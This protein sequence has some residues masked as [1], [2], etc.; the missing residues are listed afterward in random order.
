MSARIVTWLACLGAISVAAAAAEPPR[1]FDQ[2]FVDATLRV[3]VYHVGNASEELVTLDRLHRVGTWA[4]STTQLADRLDLGRYK[5]SATDVETGRVLFTHGYDS[6]FGEYRTT[7]A[8]AQGVRRTYHESVLMPFPRRP[9]ELRFEARSREGGAAT[10]GT[11]RVDP[12]DPFIAREPVP[13]DLRVVEQRGSGDPHV[14]LDL[15]IVG[16]GYTAGDEATFRR[17][18]ERFTSVLLSRE[19][20]ATL[21]HLISVRGVFRPSREPGCD[22]PGRG[23]FRD[24]SVGASFDALG[25]ERYL[26]T[27]DNRALRDIAAA[28]PYDA[29]ILMVNHDRYG[30]GG[31]YNQFSVFTAHN[32]WSE[33][34]LVHELGHSFAGL[35]DEYYTSSTAYNEFYPRGV[36]PVEPNITALLDPKALKWRELVAEGTPVPTPW[37]KEEFELIDRAYQKEREELN[38][39]DRPRL[40][41]GGA[42]GG[43]GGPQGQGRGPVAGER[44]AG[45]EDAGGVSG[46]RRGGRLRGRRLQRHRALPAGGGLHHVHQEPAPVLRGVPGG[47]RRHDPLVRGVAPVPDPTCRPSS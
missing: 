9:V 10:I 39:T 26:L 31:I 36:E 40:T 42:R 29:V 6:Y 4:G 7:G 21:A 37:E 8:A 35:A 44:G 13:G 32:Q 38:Q 23:T 30:G 41:R 17:D 12:G 5:L 2:D 47:H 14:R 18:L 25:S 16:E 34:L 43:G 28:V 33:Y 3:D 46:G 11:F 1:M 27:E 45:V 22:E 24:T 20:F 15:A 19:P